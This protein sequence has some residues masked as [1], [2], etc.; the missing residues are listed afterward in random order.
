MYK[1]NNVKERRKPFLFKSI[2]FF[3]KLFYRR[4][5]IIYEE[6]ETSHGNIFVANHSQI[7]GPLATYLYYP[8]KKKIWVI[9]QMTKLKEVPAYAFEDFWR[10]KP[11]ITHWF[12]RLLSFIIAPLSVFIM[13]HANTI[14]VYKDMR[15]SKTFRDSMETLN[16][17]EDIFL[18]P[19]YRQEY[20]HIIN[21]F[22]VNF[23]DLARV[24]YKKYNHELK[25]YPVYISKSLRK[26]MIGRPTT[27]NPNENINEERIRISEY[28][29][30]NITRLALSLP[31][32]KVIPYTNGANRVQSK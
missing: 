12:Y 3:A 8:N 5:Q 26:I 22:Q 27:F 16:N 9:G 10:D 7:H 1:V 25:F 11:K 32:H 20:N 15:I 28:L 18:Y 24:Y 21:D 2:E 19:E 29:K 13:K 17:E 14:P 4:Y 23:I 31:S 30:E 6:E